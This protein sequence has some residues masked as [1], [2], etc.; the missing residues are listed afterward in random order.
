[1]N[2]PN[3]KFISVPLWWLVERC[4]TLTATA[5]SDEYGGTYTNKAGS[6]NTR[7][8]LIAQGKT[9]DYSIRDPLNKQGPSDKTAAFDWTFPS[10]QGGN[11]GAI[12]L[13]SARI[14]IAWEQNDP[15]TYALQE[16]LCEADGDYD[17]EGYVFYPSHSFR[18][19]D[20]TH[21]WHIHFGFIRKY[22]NDQA[23]FDAI[24]SIIVG[25]SLAAW[26]VRV[27]QVG[28][29]TPPVSMTEGLTRMFMVQVEGDPTI[30]ISTSMEYRGLTSWNSFLRFRDNMK[31][32][33]HIVKTVA[34]LQDM[35][36][37]YWTADEAEIVKAVGQKIDD[38]VSDSFQMPEAVVQRL[39][40]AAREAGGSL[41]AEEVRA[42]MDSVLGD[43]AKMTA[44][45]LQKR[46]TA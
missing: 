44:D 39:E 22:L 38:A 13:Y 12:I 15:R 41:T 18:V 1:M 29:G 16:V 32:P 42:I 26:K 4:T 14:K 19:P 8:N 23:A 11:Y 34:E 17:P 35:A 6:H 9:N 36:G 5:F 30:H 24:F 2:N 25:E 27:G 7:S 3:P 40:A 21:K 33:Y 28:Q 10:A 45:E 31:V 37:R 46:L 20:R 43:T